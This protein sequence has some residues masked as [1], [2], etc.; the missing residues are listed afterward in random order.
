MEQ[1]S[2]RQLPAVYAIA[3]MDTKGS[4]LMFVAELLSSIGIPV[5]TVD[6]GTFL[7]PSIQPNVR[8]EVVAAC[9]PEGSEIV[10]AQKDR[11]RAV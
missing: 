4:E 7:P 1:Q 10:L 3:T 6:I 9:H 11:G 2:N 8:R 5:V